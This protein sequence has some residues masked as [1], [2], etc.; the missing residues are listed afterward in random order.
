MVGRFRRILTSKCYSLELSGQTGFIPRSFVEVVDTDTALEAAGDQ[1][2][3]TATADA[4]THEA[5]PVHD[6]A[7]ITTIEP[8]KHKVQQMDAHITH[9]ALG[10]HEPASVQTAMS[11]RANVP[12]EGANHEIHAEEMTDVTMAMEKPEDTAQVDSEAAAD[13]KPIPVELAQTAEAPMA[14]FNPFS[15]NF[16]EDTPDVNQV[17]MQ[18]MAPEASADQMV[19]ENTMD[20]VESTVVVTAADVAMPKLASEGSGINAG[21]DVPRE[22][23]AYGFRVSQMESS[24]DE[25]EV[26]RH[27]DDSCK[28]MSH[29]SNRPF[30]LR[31]PS[32]H[33]LHRIQT[34]SHSTRAS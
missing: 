20:A 25:D 14:D 23:G 12:V 34:S 9:A 3:S 28:V 8:V 21:V 30:S 29:N 22:S 15:D 26:F 5:A 33:L 10:T 13:V 19:S 4:T 18:E 17:D 16:V 7:T 24:D 1:P 2:L 31:G 32:A 6:V 11:T 27:V